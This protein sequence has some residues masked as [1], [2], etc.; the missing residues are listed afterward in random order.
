M[1]RWAATWVALWDVR[2]PPSV[3]GVIRIALAL[4]V[5]VDLAT[6]GLHG[7]ADLL[8]APTAAGGVA[9]WSAERAPLWYRLLPESALSAWLLWLGLCLSALGV[10]LGCFTRASA[11]AFVALSVQAASING[12]ADRAID[13]AIRIMILILA[14]SPAGKVW[15]L[16]ARRAT[17]SFAGDRSLAP[18]W[19]RYL[20]LAQLVL[21][22]WGAGLAKGGTHWYPWGDYRALYLILRDPIFATADF[23]WVF[24]PIAY[25]GTQ[26]MTAS[27]HLWELAAP[28]VLVAA[29]YD[30]T[31]ARPG[32]LRRLFNRIAVRDA[33]VGIGIAFH[34]SLALSLRLGIFPFAMLA[35]FPAF[36]RPDELERALARLSARVRGLVR[37]DRRRTSV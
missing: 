6:I 11:L 13:R 30:K 12:P 20:I 8:W 7:A 3:L 32:R 26:L 4:V 15:S 23:S 9:S 35:C 28:L 34:L 5:L 36:F 25:A 24:H 29:Y 33:Y 27:T 14:L 17:G 16:D 2:E 21:I 31:R 18:A 37:L 1:K 10:G 19:P 22:Y